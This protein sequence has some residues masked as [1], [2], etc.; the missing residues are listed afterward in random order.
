MVQQK[1]ESQPDKVPDSQI[2]QKPRFRISLAIVI[3]LF[4]LFGVIFLTVIIILSS[5]GIIT[6]AVFKDLSLIFISIIVPVLA[7]VISLIQ[8]VQSFA[9]RQAESVTASS[10]I[11]S[12]PQAVSIAQT[13]SRNDTEIA[14]TTIQ[15]S[16]KVAEGTSVIEV[17]D[18]SLHRVDWGEAPVGGN[19]YGRDK[20]RA[21]LERWIIKDNCKLVA[22]LGIGGLF[23]LG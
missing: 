8:L 21:E 5:L 1:P 22:V 9:S 10:H 3:C 17:K 15:S 11:L 16:K 6:A 19:F 20:E 12:T 23:W 13:T 4:I 2:G 18:Q 7:L 14:S